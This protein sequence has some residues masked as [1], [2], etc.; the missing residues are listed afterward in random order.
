MDSDVCYAMDSD[1]T[2]QEEANCK[3]EK[4]WEC[5][6]AIFQVFVAI[7]L[8]R[9]CLQGCEIMLEASVAFLVSLRASI[10]YHLSP[11]DSAD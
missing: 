5:T 2:M 10:F 1:C 6:T 4:P 11:Q 9:G 3:R 8:H 7:G